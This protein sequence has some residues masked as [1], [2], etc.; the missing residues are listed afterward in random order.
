MEKLFI[1]ADS[2]KLTAELS[3]K[4]TVEEREFYNNLHNISVEFTKQIIGDKK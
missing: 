2:S 1:L 3:S 4:M